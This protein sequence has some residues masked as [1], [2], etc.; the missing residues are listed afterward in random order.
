MKINSASG[1]GVVPAD[2]IWAVAVAALWVHGCQKP[3]PGMGHPGTQELMCNEP[4][5][6]SSSGGSSQLL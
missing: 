6:Q 1:M 3:N 5:T 2:G 4:S